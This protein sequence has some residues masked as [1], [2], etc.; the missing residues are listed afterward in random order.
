MEVGTMW[1]YLLSKK[2]C[3]CVSCAD[4]NIRMSKENGLLDKIHR[5]GKYGNSSTEGT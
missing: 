4:L 2:H 5:S 1:P 3:N